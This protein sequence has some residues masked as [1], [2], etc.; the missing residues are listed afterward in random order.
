MLGVVIKHLF[1]GA[2]LTMLDSSALACRASEASLAANGLEAHV[3]ASDGFSEIRGQF[4]LIVTNPPFHRGHKS[5]LTLSPALLSPIRN[6]LNPGGQFLMVANRH[7]PYRRWLDSAFGNHEVVAS[8]RVYH[9]LC[10]V[11]P[12]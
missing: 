8:S 12:V 4:D 3:V 1:S 5:V 7:L 9:L 11:Q 2:E 10:G 6:F